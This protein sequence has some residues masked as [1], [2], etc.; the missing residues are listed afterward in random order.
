MN[1]LKPDGTFKSIQ[2]LKEMYSDIFNG[3][4]TTNTIFHC[5]SGVTACHS[6]LALDFAGFNTPSLYVGSWSEW[7]RNNKPMIT[8]DE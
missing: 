4:E 2:E 1:N 3:I 5:G 6:I 7:S 8:K